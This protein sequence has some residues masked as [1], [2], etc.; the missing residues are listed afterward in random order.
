MFSCKMRVPLRVKQQTLGFFVKDGK[1]WLGVKVGGKD[2]GKGRLNG[3]G[4]DVKPNETIEEATRR[5]FKEETG[6]E[7]I[8]MEKRAVIEFFFESE[9]G[10]VREVHV[11]W[12]SKCSG[13]PRGSKEMTA[14]PF[15]LTDLENLYERMWAGDKLWLSMFFAGKKFRGRVYYNNPVSNQVIGKEFWEV[16]EL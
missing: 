1:V 6:V 2:F 12:I 11:F 4:G 7:I 16:D 15:F 13:Q 9:P 8:A 5:E 14:E 10:I 3:F